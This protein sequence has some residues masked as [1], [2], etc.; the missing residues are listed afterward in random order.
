MFY[1]TEKFLP[2]KEPYTGPPTLLSRVKGL[3]RRGE[4]FY[5]FSRDPEIPRDRPRDGFSRDPDYWLLILIFKVGV[6]SDFRLVFDDSRTDEG[7]TE[8]VTCFTR[9]KKIYPSPYDSRLTT[10][11]CPRIPDQTINNPVPSR[12]AFRLLGAIC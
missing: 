6:L 12:S 11:L 1:S 9:P 10:S 5:R 7:N 8:T 2:P 4:G 3:R